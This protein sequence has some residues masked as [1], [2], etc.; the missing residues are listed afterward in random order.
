MACFVGGG[1]VGANGR[2]RGC[3]RPTRADACIA[4][5]GGNAGVLHGEV[6]SVA[7]SATRKLDNIRRAGR[8]AV[9]FRSGWEWASVEGPARV[10]SN[11]P[12]LLRDIFTAAGGTHDDWD[13]YARVMAEE[14][15][16]AVFV[17]PERITAH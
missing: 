4:A 17:T 5:S 8:A 3:G 9:T 11:D 6:A 16:V 7:R 14:N 15:R 10:G 2:A 1:G 13:A 12:K